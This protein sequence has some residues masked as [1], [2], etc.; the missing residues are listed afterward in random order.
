MRGIRD[1]T[2][3]FVLVTEDAA[4]HAGQCWRRPR[5]CIWSGG[6]DGAQCAKGRAAGIPL[7]N[8]NRMIR[9]DEQE[10]VQRGVGGSFSLQAESQHS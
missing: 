1:S 9:R 8:L 5:R 4:C 3:H 2:H 6:L 10:H 7:D